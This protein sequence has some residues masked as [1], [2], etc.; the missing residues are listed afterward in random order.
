MMRVIPVLLSVVVTVS[1]L[2]ASTRVR[3]DAVP[4]PPEDCPRGAVG[5]TGH[6]GVWCDPTTCAA[7]DTCEDSRDCQTQ[8]LCITHETYTPGGRPGPDRP[9]TP[10]SR[11]IAEA[12]CNAGETCADGSRCVV[13]RRC[14]KPSLADA[15]NPKNAGCGCALTD[16]A[17]AATGLGLA[18]AGVFALVAARRR[19]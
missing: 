1:V 16:R 13:A 19:R 15:F 3:A 17:D 5:R 2:C 8:G 6:S 18:L 14:V 4:S 11:D 12:A 7:S 10:L 9:S